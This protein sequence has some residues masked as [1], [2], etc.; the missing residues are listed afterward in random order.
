MSNFEVTSSGM[1]FFAFLITILNLATMIFWFVV[2]WRAM[3][4]HEEIAAGL[5][6]LREQR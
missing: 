2:G 6:D 4:A 5:R 1:P 3:R